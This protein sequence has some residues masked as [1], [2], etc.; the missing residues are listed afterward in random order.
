VLCTPVLGLGRG[1]AAATGRGEGTKDGAGR[2]TGGSAASRSPK[3]SATLTL[4]GGG[5]VVAMESRGGGRVPGGT[6]R[7]FL[8][9]MRWGDES[10][11][12]R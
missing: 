4:A 11:T 12:G 10:V 1:E 8:L 2:E 3:A 6:G 7:C 5:R 9:Q